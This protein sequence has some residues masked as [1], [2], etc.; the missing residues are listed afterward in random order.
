MDYVLTPDAQTIFAKFGARP[1]M[2]VLGKLDL[3][4]EAKASWLPDDQYAKVNQIDFTQ[5]SPAEIEKVWTEQV[6]TGG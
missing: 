4:A 6:A 3:P 5:V 2:Y 1:I